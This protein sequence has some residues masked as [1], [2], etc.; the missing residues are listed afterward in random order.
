MPTE[1]TVNGT[2]EYGND[3]YRSLYEEIMYD[4]GKL[5]AIEGS[6]LL[7]R[8]EDPLFIVSVRLRSKPAAKS[9]GDVAM[10]RAERGM[11]YISI[12]DEMYAPGM[13]KKLWDTYGR[14]RVQQ[15]DR[16]DITVEGPDTSAEVDALPVE[17]AEQP[18]QDILGA[19]AR[20]LPEGIRNRRVISGSS[21]VTVMATEEIVQPDQ[22]A[23]AEKIHAAVSK[24]A[25]P[26]V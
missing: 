26:D 8:P 6:Y 1:T 17:S 25:V 13:L 22:I 24:G 10:T 4:V 16:L 3:R 18:I 9:I 20:V 14:D 19:L 2:D 12:R 15:T 11:V 23:M 21:T 5:T 7:L